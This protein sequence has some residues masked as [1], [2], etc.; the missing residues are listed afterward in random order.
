MAAPPLL[1]PTASGFTCAINNSGWVGSGIRSGPCPQPHSTPCAGRT[2]RRAHSLGD[3][4]LVLSFLT[5]SF[6]VSYLA[7]GKE[8]W[9]FGFKRA[10]RER[11]FFSRIRE[12]FW[13]SNHSSKL[14]TL[15]DVLV[16]I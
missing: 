2:E 4:A 10:F 7:L 1:V 11:F 14:N 13:A 3:V 5:T 9:K 12:M 15:K 16:Q 6:L 8:A